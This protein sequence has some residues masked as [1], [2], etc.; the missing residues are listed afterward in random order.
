MTLRYRNY[1]R[2]NLFR[3]CLPISVID[4]VASLTLLFLDEFEGN[5]YI[6]AAIESG[7]TIQTCATMIFIPDRNYTHYKLYRSCL[8]IYGIAIVLA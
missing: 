7:F 6:S 3:S 1:T 2:Y 8:P 5:A 4:I